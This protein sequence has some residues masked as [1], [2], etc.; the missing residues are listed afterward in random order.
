MTRNEHAVIN[1]LCNPVSTDVQCMHYRDTAALRKYSALV[2]YRP[3]HNGPSVRFGYY[4]PDTRRFTWKSISSNSPHRTYSM[5]PRA[6][7]FWI[8]FA[9]WRKSCHSRYRFL[10]ILRPDD[11]NILSFS[12]GFHNSKI[13]TRRFLIIHPDDE[14]LFDWNKTEE[15][16][17]ELYVVPT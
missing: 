10:S 1:T 2:C 12:N 5:S 17:Y 7:R 16:L 14:N 11:E 13:V 15:R 3:D 6:P 8:Q 9:A 4:P